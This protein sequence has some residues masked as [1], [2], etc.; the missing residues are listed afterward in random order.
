MSNRRKRKSRAVRHVRLN[1]QAVGPGLG[2]CPNKRIGNGK[3][4][5]DDLLAGSEIVEQLDIGC[6][7]SPVS[8]PFAQI[9]VIIFMQLPMMTEG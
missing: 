9:L 3:G 1:A 8:L 7:F 4:Y 2:A 5:P 6:N